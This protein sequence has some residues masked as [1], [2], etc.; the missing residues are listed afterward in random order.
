[1]R[2]RG[3]SWLVEVDEVRPKPSWD[4]F[5]RAV[6]RANRAKLRMTSKATVGP[7]DQA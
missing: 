5:M 7:D 1:M 3:V 6:S 2:L 4:H